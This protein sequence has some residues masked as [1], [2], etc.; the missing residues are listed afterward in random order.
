MLG[1]LRVLIAI[2]SVFVGIGTVYNFL[3][4]KNRKI[5]ANWLANWT[6]AGFDAAIP[7][8]NGLEAALGPLTAAFVAAFK[9][10]GGPIATDIQGALAPVIRTGLDTAAAGLTASGESTP[11]NALGMAADALVDAFGFGIGSAGATAAFEAVF[12]EKLNVLNGVGPMLAQM[13]GFDEVQAAVRGPLYENAFGKS[14]DYHFRSLFKPELPNEADAVTW[15]SRRLL[16]DAQLS[17][18]FNFS[19]LK[20]EYEAP[21]VASA[22]RAVQPRALATLFQDTE[23][24]IDAMTK[25]LQFAGIR[26]QEIALMLPAFVWNAVKNVRNEYI[27][28][29]VRS[30]ELGTMTPAELD[31]ELQVLKYSQEARDLIQLT[32][33][34]RK[35]LQLAE[36]Y[37]KSIS[38]AYKT[39][40]ITDAQYVPSLEAIGIGAADAQAHYAVDSIA[41]TGKALAQA[42]RAEER[43]ASQR[44]RAGVAAAVAAYKS[45][46]S[47]AA[48]LEGALLAAGMDPVVAAL[49]VEVQTQRRDGNVVFVYGV[50]LPRAAAVELREKVAALAIQVRARLVSPGDA[51]TALAS[52]GVPRANALALVAE[53]AATTVTPARVGVLEPR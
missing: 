32:V 20:T 13:A 4:D 41:K 8:L 34:T 30:T 52:Y 22:Y 16:T 37:R 19:G 49:S 40:Q 24:P 12:P 18:I 28:A 21:F 5:V 43:L 17:T 42:L 44:M 1:L 7:L 26:D 47:D 39:G 45:G 48:A 36:L 50:E 33:A 3:G 51:L 23:V 35:E 31:Q 10:Y 15:H 46:F 2:V 29:A 6:H 25:A 9:Q 38:E 14:L 27:S 11:D 53:W